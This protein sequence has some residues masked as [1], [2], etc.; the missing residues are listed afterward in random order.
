MT[1]IDE[2]PCQLLNHLSPPPTRTTD[3]VY[4]NQSREEAGATL[5]ADARRCTLYTKGGHLPIVTDIDEESCQLLN[6]LSPP[7][8][9]T[10][11]AVHSNQSRQEAGATHAADACQPMLRAY[12]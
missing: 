3:A 7:P 6:H 11:D 1:D 5:A 9:R 4:S 12:K 10:T 2:E 8:K